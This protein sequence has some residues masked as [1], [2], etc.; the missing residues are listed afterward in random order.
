MLLG[1]EFLSRVHTFFPF[2]CGIQTLAIF[3]SIGYEMQS[4]KLFQIK[5]QR[6]VDD[7]ES[8]ALNDLFS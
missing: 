3:L 7:G 2:L 8:Q 5:L 1:S 6:L 4:L